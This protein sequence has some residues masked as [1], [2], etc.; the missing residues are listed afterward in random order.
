MKLFDNFLKKLKT[1]R[2]TFFT[3]VFTLLTAYLIVDRF[4]ELLFMCFA[5]M[6]VSYW[7]P[8]QYTLAMACPVL[9]FMFC[10]PSKF[11]KSD[12]IKISFFYCYCIALYLI[13][14]TMVVQ[15]LNFGVWFLLVSAPNYQEIFTNFSELIRPALTAISLYIPLVT[16]YKLFLWLFQ[17]INDPIFP[18]NYKDSI[19]DFSGVDLSSS[20][21]ETGP[22]SFEIEICKDRT[23]G[24]SVKI[25]EGRRF[26]SSL[27]V[28]PSGT[29]K[30]SL[31]MEPMIARDLEKKYFFKELSKE[32]AFSALKSGIANLNCPYDKNYINEN[33]TLNFI[34]P[35][36]GKEKAFKTHFEKLIYY[37][38]PDGKFVFKDLGLTSVTPDHEHTA[39][40]AN[41]AKNLGLK[42]NII[43]PL[44]P[45]SVGLNPFIITSPAVCGLI[46]SLII[47]GLYN[48]SSYTAELVYMQD[49]ALQAIQNLVI[50]LKLVYP[51]L[52]EGVLPNL[53]DLLFC[54]NDFDYV[55]SLCQELEKDPELSREYALQI[56]Y[57]KQHFYKN[58]GGRENM[59]RYIHF[60]SSQLDVLLRSGY[61]RSIICNRY[62]NINYEQILE[63]NE[64]VF[65]CTRPTDIGG[66]AHK[67]FGYFFLM[68][69]QYCVEGRPGNENSRTPHF[70]Y[71]DDFDSYATPFLSDLFTVYRKFKVGTIFSIPN[72]ASLGGTSSP[73]MQSL[74]SNCPTKISFGN[75]TPEDYSWWEAE[76]GKR[77]EWVVGPSYDMSK[78]AYSS[79]LGSPKWEWK[80]ILNVAK[81]QGL[82]FKTI[83]YKTKDK[84]GKN[85]VN[86]G[87][88]D[89]LDSKYKEP[90]KVK[91]YNF[92]KYNGP[93]TSSDS[94]TSYKQHKFNPKKIDFEDN[95]NIN[96]V[97]TDVSDSK[98]LF[99]NENAISYN[100][101]KNDN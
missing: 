89:F 38:S 96:P 8:I 68:L 78:G 81:L 53:E 48:P 28:G 77:R 6:S 45:N 44:D 21:S 93:T 24:K 20:S 36:E 57:F 64:L 90:Q 100:F 75:C 82:K 1:D 99:E 80:D 29:G 39:R 3:Y 34:S 51:K 101:K 33:F 16:F 46:I 55:E 97:Q 63:N 25:I 13:G 65:I 84:K 61:V 62:N 71:V 27:I 50:L 85:I 10:Y 76:F 9:A 69:M 4:V 59:K 31:I 23:T 41:V 52:N 49:V 26:A 74:L 83:V 14:I 42:V 15:W 7:N 37:T 54:F 35:V 72:L 58:S 95:A 91:F 73:F 60:A 32:L 18:N 40:I 43:D 98:Y 92:D 87:V 12:K 86:Y 66:T 11:S 94:S 30:S 67:G 22:Y 19:L 5:G 88:V 70:L 79:A 2:N 47:K 17:V 56:S